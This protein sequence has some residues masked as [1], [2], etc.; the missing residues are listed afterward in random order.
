MEATPS[1]RLDAFR[2]V[3]AATGA[4][5]IGVGVAA[6]VGWHQDIPALKSLIPGRVAMNPTTALSFVL[7]GVSLVLL[8]AGQP[9]PGIRRLGAWAA[10]GVTGVGVLKLMAVMGGPDLAIDLLLFRDQ[11]DVAGS[12]PNRMAPNTAFNFLLVGLALLTLDL[13]TRSG[14][15]ISQRIVLAPALL[16]LMAV[17]GY[18]YGVTTFYGVT[19][20]IPMAL[21]T[22]LTFCGLC[23]GI[24]LA[25][26]DHDLARVLT[27][28]S[29][30]GGMAR[31]ML[32]V[33]ALIAVF[34]W[35]RLIGEGA[36]LYTP[37]FGL[38]LTVL[39]SMILLIWVV[40]NTAGSL[41]RTDLDRQRAA[42]ALQHAHD[43]LETRVADRTAELAAANQALVLEMNERSAAEES[44]RRTEDQLRQSQK[45]DAVGRLAGGVAHDFNNMLTAILGFSQ[46]MRFRL[47]E[48]DPARQDTEEIEK[49]AM[50]AA[51]LTRQLLAFSRQQVLEPKVLDLNAVITEAGTLLRRVIGADIDLHTATSDDLGRVKADP[52]QIDQ[53]IMNL[54]VNARDAMPDG[55]KLTIETANIELSEDYTRSHVG[56]KPGRY[57][58]LAVSDTGCGMDA[59]TQ[60]RIFE[61]FYTTKGVGKGTGLGLS[62]V[63]G[64]VQQSDGHIEVYSEPGRG[65]AFKVYLPRIDTASERLSLA[66]PQAQPTRGTETILVVEDEEQVRYV[67]RQTLEL[68]G[69]SVIEAPDGRRALE[70]CEQPGFRIDLVVTDI[71]M[72]E[73]G[74]P[75]LVRRLERLEREWPV[76][77]ISGYT[78]RAIVHHGILSAGRAFLQKP[79]TPDALLRKVR[80]VMDRPH[81][82]A[83]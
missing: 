27:G 2:W 60:S 1:R 17:L 9:L 43:D 26:P 82:Q 50:R 41:D 35:L 49:A 52:G 32:P 34:G 70:L 22:A 79:F 61:P 4:M 76:L 63:Y 11:L 51:A 15:R 66:A 54:V 33:V 56:V 12:L 44:L 6:L 83:A 42:D 20:Y 19:S 71:V 16:S 30:G 31:R 72:P 7:G 57:V 65:A 74:G 81:S 67:I 39:S 58:M 47:A 14:R 5:A 55:G 53:I 8:R 78:D 36:G 77:Y 3:P 13:E 59:E 73:L 24:F 80:E 18:A 38:S 69:Y 28:D 29:V 45:M 64:I 62:T 48:D 23:A 10:A 75:E 46:L 37:E 25:R 68:S 21:N 40:W